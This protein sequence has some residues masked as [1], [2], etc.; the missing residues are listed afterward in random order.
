MHLVAFLWLFAAGSQAPANAKSD[1]FEQLSKEATDARGQNRTA[2]AIA[3][4]RQAV[5]LRPSWA[6]G[7][8]FL[9]ELLYDQNQYAEARDALRRLVAVDPK[10]GPGFALLGLCE[11]QTREYRQ[12]LA[13]INEGR[14]LGLG[15]D[16]QVRRVVLYH[17]MLLDTRFGMY[18]QALEVLER[19]LKLG[20]FGPAVVEAAGLAGL[21]RP[22]S[23]EELR[24]DQKDLVEEAG[25]AVL[26]M[27]EQKPADAQ[28]YFQ[29]LLAN[30]PSAPGVHYLYATFLLPDNS[31][32]GLRELQKELQLNPKHAAALVYS[33]LEYLRLGNLQE[34]LTYAQR[35]VDAAPQYFATHLVL[36]KL[37]VTSGQTAKAIQQLELAKKQAPDSPQVHFE[38]AS[39]YLQAG[40]DDDAARERAEFVRLKKLADETLGVT[41]A[42]ASEPLSPEE[43]FQDLARRA[44]AA[45]DSHPDEAAGLYKQALALQAK[46]AEGWLSLGA[47]F[48]ELNRFAEASD[49]LRRG[50]ELTPQVGAGWALLGLTESRLDD[51]YQALADIR[52]GES[53]GL[54]KNHAFEIAVR[55]RAAEV[56]VESSAFDEALVQLR[57]LAGTKEKIPAAEEAMGLCVLSVPEDI[58]K[59]SP[60]RR[61]VVD[62][63]GKAAWAYANQRMD[64]AA[65][66]Y[67]QLLAEFP[68][69]P[70]VHYAH[71]VYLLDT[72]LKGALA[73]FQKELQVDP[74]HWPALLYSASIQI[75]QGSP[76]LAIASLQ[77]ALQIIP[78]RY[79]WMCHADLGHANLDKN[80]LNSAIAELEDASRQMPSNANVHF[81]LAQAY[82]RAGRK[83]DA[84]IERAAFEKTKVEQDP[85]SVPGFKG[86][87]P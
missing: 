44:G 63:A 18:E 86:L 29:V 35:S 27:T 31:A 83:A 10:A 4:Y 85:L 66:A 19:V 51:E 1:S 57:P 25:R 40:R 45:L 71:G 68:N 32:D 7:W 17:A 62:L 39:A 64:E 69:E 53:L 72:D 33:A 15:D 49:A 48:Y 82:G 16:V 42:S 36:G 23:P 8:W 80:N 55:V 74:Q 61:A 5:A 46:W 77:K 38:L 52:K 14:R 2:E 21:R 75:R 81:L 13:D 41:A 76:G 54:G 67:R 12:A 20:A 65:A 78:A 6:E 43:K 28:K 37:L 9:G 50:L 87:R 26:A 58:T 70:G 59:I 34:A 56:L 73:E 30:H 11:Y 79:R 84:A 3:L 60:Q 22:I 47:A 24:P